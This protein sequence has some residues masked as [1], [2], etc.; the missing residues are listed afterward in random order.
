[1]S[2]EPDHFIPKNH[3]L[4]DHFVSA[5]Q[6]MPGS[7][8]VSVVNASFNVSPIRTTFALPTKALSTLKAKV[9][10]IHGPQD[11]SVP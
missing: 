7:S 1:M 5:A 2:T 10:V 4:N 3:K 9:V 11:F 8:E 6:N